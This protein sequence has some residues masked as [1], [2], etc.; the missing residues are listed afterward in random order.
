MLRGCNYA[1]V[2]AFVRWVSCWTCQLPWACRI[3]ACEQRL[4]QPCSHILSCC[5]RRDNVNAATSD[6]QTFPFPSL[7]KQL[8]V[9]AQAYVTGCAFV[10]PGSP[11]AHYDDLLFGLSGFY[12]SNEQRGK[13]P[14]AASEAPL[15]W[16]VKTISKFIDLWHNNSLQVHRKHFFH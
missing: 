14:S 5:R 15:C 1:T 9:C 11:G 7:T 12:L 3:I 2:C 13:P 6:T 8:N 16:R 4:Q 10:S